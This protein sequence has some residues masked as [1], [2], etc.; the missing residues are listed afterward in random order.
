MLQKIKSIR[1]DKILIAVVFSMLSH[2]VSAATPMIQKDTL[3]CN[4]FGYLTLYKPVKTVTDVVICISGDGGWNKGIEGI[5]LHLK[6][7]N[8]LIIGVDI[9][10]VFKY[11]K[12][13]KSA[14][15]YPAADFERMSQFVQK[16]LGYQTYT[17]PVLLG[18]SSGAT[19]VY[20][21]VAQAPQNTFRAGIAM[22]FCPDIQID[23]PLCLGSGKFINTKLANGKGYDLGPAQNLATPFISLQG[24]TDQVCNYQA[25]VA[26]LKDVPNAKVISLAKV[27]H[28]YGVEKNWLPQFMLA[29]NSIL[30]KKDES[31]PEGVAKNLNLPLHVTNSAAGKISPYMVVFIS[32]DGGWTDFDQQ[33][34]TSFASKG[35]PVIGLDALKYFWQKKSPEQTTVDVARIIETYLEEWK[36]EKVILMGYSFGADVMPFVY[37]RLPE[38]FKKNISGVGLL[39]PSKDTDFEVHVSELFNIGDAPAGLSVPNEINK[40]TDIHPICFFGKDEDDLPIEHISKES[41]RI[42]YLDGGHHYT[43]SFIEVSKAMMP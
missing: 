12:K 22:G 2:A 8:T 42:I 32:G 26:F 23:K 28:G 24:Q 33:M 29:Y 7:E 9:R 17:I 27:G 31:I 37:N 30:E 25:T 36:K 10:Q 41:A 43:D 20:G 19:L 4:G 11:M 13:S 16:K 40:I 21:L 34:A 39:S 6:N 15:L 14:C 35:A 5:A 3:A 38:K 18:Y 1:I